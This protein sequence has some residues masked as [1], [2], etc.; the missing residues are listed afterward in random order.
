MDRKHGGSVY[1]CSGF[2]ELKMVFEY[3]WQDGDDETVYKIFWQVLTSNSRHSR[4]LNG[5]E[6]KAKATQERMKPFDERHRCPSG[7]F[8]SQDI[9]S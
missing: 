6:N 9:Y 8:S 4:Q 7:F 3:D 2:I 5:P 1:L